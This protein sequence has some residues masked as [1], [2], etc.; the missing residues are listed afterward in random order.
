M[1]GGNRAAFQETFHQLRHQVLAVCR[2]P[3]V[4]ADQKLVAV[5]VGHDEK[6]E[7]SFELPFAA[8]QRRITFQ[9]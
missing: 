9:E 2:A 1:D 7:R 5:L 3:S 8:L 6:I 4:A